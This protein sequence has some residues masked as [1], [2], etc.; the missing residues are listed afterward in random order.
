MPVTEVKGS[1]WFR[2]A[3]LLWRPRHTLGVFFLSQA[4]GQIDQAIGNPAPS[5]KVISGLWPARL[6]VK[7]GS[8]TISVDVLQP[9]SSAVRPKLIV[10][11]NPSIG[12]NSDLTAVATTITVWQT[13]SL[14]FT[15]TVN[16]AVKILLV[17]EDGVNPCWFDN[18]RVL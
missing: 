11:A 16:G 18:V 8:R 14:Q 15:A 7:S 6:A 5:L 12:L 10:K 2:V 4:Q 9:V 13:L 17:N 3:H 1:S